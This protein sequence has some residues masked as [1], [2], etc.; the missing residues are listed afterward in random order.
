MGFTNLN[1][2]PDWS[3]Y[4]LKVDSNS[5]ACLNYR[6]VESNGMANILVWNGSVRF[7]FKP[8]WDSSTTNSGTGPGSFGHL[9]EIG[10]LDSADGWWALTVNQDGTALSF[11]TQTNG[12]SA[13]NLTESINWTSNDWHQIVLSYSATNSLLYLDGLLEIAGSGVNNYPGMKLLVR[14]D[15]AL[16]VIIKATASP[17][18]NSMS[19]KRSITN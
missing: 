5:P 8:D 3:G 13:T 6:S 4:A 1:C 18:D 17:K 12:L 19:W 7:W 10:N 16:E 9:L 15:L 14:M 2:V 11:I